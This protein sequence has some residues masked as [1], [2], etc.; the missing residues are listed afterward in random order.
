M[1]KTH[2][3]RMYEV[4]VGKE[5]RKSGDSQSTTSYVG[6]LLLEAT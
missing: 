2:I 1:W 4:G 6:E 5:F 3:I